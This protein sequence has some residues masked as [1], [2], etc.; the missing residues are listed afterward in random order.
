MRNRCRPTTRIARLPGLFLL[1]AAAAQAPS[2]TTLAPALPVAGPGRHQDAV[3]IAD[4]T[5][6][7]FGLPSPLLSAAERRAFAVGNSFF[8][9]NWVTAPAS[10]EGRDGLGPLWNA[11]SCS[12]C[13]FKDGRSRP[14]EADEVERHGL[15][16]RIGI[17][18][19]NGPDAPH[20][21]YGAQIQDRA[22]LGIAAEA[23]VVIETRDVPGRY[24]DGSPFTLLAPSYT[25]RELGYGPLTAPYGLGPRVA[26]QLIGLGLLEAIPAAAIVAQA[27]PDDRD[28]DGISGRAH[29]VGTQLGRFGWKAGQPTVATQTAAAFVND[30]GITSALQPDEVLTATEAGR[31]TFTS[32]GTPEIDDLAFARVVFYTRTLAV[33]AP[34]QTD[35]PQVMAGREHFQAFGCAACH[36]PTF[37]TGAVDWHAGHAAQTIHPF[38]DLLLHDLG[39]ELADGKHDGEAS[40]AEW[41]TA[42]L[43]G[44]GL[45]PVVNGHSRYLHDGRARDLAEAILWHGGEAMAA[46]ERFRSAPAAERAALLAFLGSL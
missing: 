13:H 22:N 46:K 23:S 5:A 36:T 7:A 27:D 40:P 18:T 32:G 2:P 19:R 38:T 25:L 41:R 10:T 39:P 30:M 43:W 20:P 45:I 9:Q 3:T 14:P 26:P 24:G 42:P 44:I 12:S 11:R 8:K 21:V 1:T 37:V 16:I 31:I 6:N 15:L 17:P 4:A 33:P 35:D 34:R 29:H 28:G